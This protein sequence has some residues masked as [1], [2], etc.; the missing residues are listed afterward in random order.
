MKENVKL[1]CYIRFYWTAVVE[2]DSVDKRKQVPL[3]NHTTLHQQVLVHELAW[4]V[5]TII[6]DEDNMKVSSLWTPHTEHQLLFCL[7]FYLLNQPSNQKF[8][9]KWLILLQLSSPSACSVFTSRWVMP[10]FTDRSG[11]IP[12][13]RCM[14]CGSLQSLPSTLWVSSVS[15]SLLNMNLL[16]IQSMNLLS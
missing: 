7:P 14:F 5:V 6:V 13:L 11:P 1:F 16:Q 9:F 2:K 3:I 12:K 10:V 8:L 4:S 15:N